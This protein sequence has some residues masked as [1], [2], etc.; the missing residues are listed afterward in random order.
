MVVS[1]EGFEENAGVRDRRDAGHPRDEPILLEERRRCGKVAGQHQVVGEEVQRKLQLHQRARGARDLHLSFGQRSAGVVVPHLVGND[2]GHS[3]PGEPQDTIDVCRP[4]AERRNSGERSRKEWR[5]RLMSL[6]EPDGERIKHKVDRAR[7]P[8]AS[9]AV[10]AAFAAA[11]TPA[12]RSGL[13]SQIAAESA[14]RYVSRASGS[15]SDS[16]CVAALSNRRTASAPRRWSNAI[17]PRRRSTCARRRSD[18]SFASTA[19][20]SPS[21]ASSAPTSRLAAAAASVR[22]ARRAASV[23]N[24]AARSKSADAARSP[25]RDLARSA[26][27]SSSSAISSSCVTVA[28]AAVPHSPVWIHNRVGRPPRAR[29]E[30]RAAHALTPRDRPRR[31]P[32][33]GESEP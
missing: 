20:N 2:S 7:N 5:R 13:P 18:A 25:P 11:A 28:F 17:C 26:A 32:M 19:G 12:W 16:S 8:A 24:N 3:I 10:A 33:G 29:D 14:S 21:A 6:R 4:D 27:C 22:S 9:G 31:A 23:V 1:S 30:H 15:A